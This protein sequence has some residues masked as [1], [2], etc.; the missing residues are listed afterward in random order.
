MVEELNLEQGI[1][2]IISL[3]KRVITKPIIIG[4]Y[5]NVN[6]GKNYLK[7]KLY[8]EIW[9]RETPK[10]EPD[11]TNM[12]YFGKLT[13]SLRPISFFDTVH[14]NTFLKISNSKY[15]FY[16]D[17]MFGSPFLYDPNDD[18]VIKVF[19]KKADI[20]VCIYN[21]KLT[22]EEQLKLNT[23]YPDHIHVL[24]KNLESK[25]KR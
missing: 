18:A 4:I 9:R 3:S 21:P 15:I 16:E 2:K 14:P 12:D 13:D 5:G 10:R 19:G 24:I 23:K 17:P 1:N 8:E 20:K 25:Q 22:P 7:K 11:E 6:N